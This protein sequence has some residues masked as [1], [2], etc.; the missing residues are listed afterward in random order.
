MGTWPR[1]FKIRNDLWSCRLT[2]QGHKCENRQYLLDGVRQAFRYYETLLGSRYRTFRIRK[3]WPWMTFN[4]RT[5]ELILVTRTAKGGGAA[6]I[7]PAMI[8]DIV[9]VLWDWCMGFSA[10]DRGMM[11]APHDI[12]SLTGCYVLRSTWRPKPEKYDENR[13]FSNK[14][15]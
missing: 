3:N 15:A 11:A 10:F 6:R 1:R 7:P 12:K 5:A 9:Q 14:R 13:P 4:T 2:F 8:V